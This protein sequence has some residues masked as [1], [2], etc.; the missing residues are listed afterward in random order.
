MSWD[1]NVLGLVSTSKTLGSGTYLEVTSA[2]SQFHGASGVDGNYVNYMDQNHGWIAATS[3]I[4]GSTNYF[5]VL[6]ANPAA[7]MPFSAGGG[8]C[9]P[10]LGSST[11]YSFKAGQPM[12]GLGWLGMAHWGNDGANCTYDS[13]G[14]DS[15]VDIWFSMAYLWVKGTSGQGSLIRV[16][17]NN[18]N[19]SL[20]WSNS[21]CTR[22]G[23]ASGTDD[24]IKSGSGY[25]WPCVST[26]TG[27]CFCPG[28]GC[29]TGGFV[30][31][32]S[33]ATTYAP[34]ASD[35]KWFI[36]GGVEETNILL[37][38]GPRIVRPY[39]GYQAWDRHICVE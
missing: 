18:S 32:S 21:N 22:N 23:G 33:C 37:P 34:A 6:K 4:T 1:A 25:C 27:I 35:P 39:G 8:T 10:S 29:A 11:A 24:D 15:D 30:A 13:D 7:T 36:Y 12:N 2:Y 14:I 17:S 26:G 9:R 20:M 28:A 16:E 31:A 5:K 38:G 19:N 3:N